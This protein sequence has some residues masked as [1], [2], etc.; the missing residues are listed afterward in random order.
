MCVG[1][2]SLS[3]SHITFKIEY[4]DSIMPKE[5][6]VLSLSFSLDD[7]ILAAVPIPTRSYSRKGLLLLLLCV[8]RR[9]KVVGMRRRRRRV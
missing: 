3:L 8:E 9:Q 2:R 4:S 1:K 6:C 5:P 7:F